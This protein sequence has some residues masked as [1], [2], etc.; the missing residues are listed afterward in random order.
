M[1]NN[2]TVRDADR[3][4]R[5]LGIDENSKDLAAAWSA[6]EEGYP[7]AAEQALDVTALEQHARRWRVPSEAL[8]SLVTTARCVREH[9]ALL[10]LFWHCR[11]TLTTRAH[12]FVAPPELSALGAQAGYFQVLLAV[13]GLPA[14]L[15]RHRALGVPPAVTDATLDDLSLWMRHYRHK[16]GRWGLAQIHWLRNHI[17]GDLLR[18]GRLQFMPIRWNNGFS[19]YMHQ[20]THDVCTLAAPETAY[21][22]DGYPDGVN[23]VFDP[24]PWRSVVRHETNA[25]VGNPIAANGCARRATVRLTLD[26]WHPMLSNGDDV[27]DVHIPAEQPL[28]PAACRQSLD[29]GLA[30]LQTLYPAQTFRAFVC[31]SWLLDS[32]LAALLPPS[33]NIVRFQRMFRL[34]PSS[35]GE[36]QT[37]ERVFGCT[38]GAAAALPTA[39]RL[40][41]ACAQHIRRGGR[42]YEGGGYIL[43]NQAIPAVYR[44]NV[45][46]SD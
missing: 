7:S 9:A 39:T 33:A 40:Q 19:A 43:I 22:N 24:Y 18:V 15:E 10:R 23:G 28:D 3:V 20:S 41:Q 14:L 12:R 4:F 35:H 16:H 11:T 17:L 34:Y 13:A 26:A 36:V 32:Q 1:S 44:R 25:V 27:L 8:S 46:R 31:C 2:S 5:A 29:D 21:R 38:P 37:F 30:L 45:A 6:S 42:F